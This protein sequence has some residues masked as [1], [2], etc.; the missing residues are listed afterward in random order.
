M[1][2]LKSLVFAFPLLGSAELIRCATGNPS[3]KLQNAHTNQAKVDTANRFN[4]KINTHPKV[5][6]NTFVHIISKGPAQEQGNLPQA[7][8]V[9]QVHWGSTYTLFA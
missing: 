4:D 2:I 7:K 5:S 6:V 9:D 3:S 1:Q 8:I